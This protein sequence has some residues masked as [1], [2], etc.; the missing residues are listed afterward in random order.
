MAEGV[1]T[2]MRQA[3]DL[4]RLAKF[5]PASTRAE[6]ELSRR[7]V[8]AIVHSI[9]TK[10]T[11]T[12][13]MTDWAIGKGADVLL[14]TC[15]NGHSAG[16]RERLPPAFKEA[17]KELASTKEI[18]EIHALYREL[19][20][21][22]LG[23]DA[24]PV[25]SDTVATS[26]EELDRAGD[27]GV[28]GLANKSMV[29]LRA[30]LGLGPKSDDT[31]ALPFFNT[32]LAK[33]G[34]TPHSKSWPN[35][36]AQGSAVPLDLKQH[37]YVG[38][39]ALARLGFS[40]SP[41]HHGAML[42]DEVGLGKTAQVIGLFAYL[43]HV[44]KQDAL[45]LPRPPLLGKWH[46]STGTH[47]LTLV[48]PPQMTDLSSASPQRC[49]TGR[50]STPSRRPSFLRSPPSSSAFTHRAPWMSSSTKVAGPRIGHFGTRCGP[51]RSNPSA[52]G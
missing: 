4:A 20:E 1:S 49:R 7:T 45:G 48:R 44:R 9:H 26:A 3:N 37:Q 10:D 11:D 28:S 34:T 17:L 31:P 33:D 5:G 6:A 50:L 32:H 43:M 19:F 51:S 16:P 41:T 13:S 42:A 35:K 46:T 2:F 12:M 25:V 8:R 40:D 22:P 18:E 30:L 24:T 36:V 27:L 52:T 38:V 21:T 23:Q 29:E 14:S 47:P 39:A 15:C